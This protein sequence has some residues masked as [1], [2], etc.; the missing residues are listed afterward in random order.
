MNPSTNEFGVVGVILPD[1]R[2]DRDGAR[3]INED[4]GV[5][6]ITF[7]VISRDLVVQARYE[8]MR[9]AGESH[10]MAEMLATR[11]FPG[12]KT[13]A[14]FNE[15]KFS[16]DD[17]RIGAEQTWLRQQAEA[18]GVSTAG[19]WYCRGLASFPGDP[20]GW[21]GDRGDVL[22]VA[23]EKNMTVHG[24]VEH[25]GYE[26]DPGDDVTIGDDII[27]NEVQDILD[28]NPFADPDHVRDEVYRLRSG[29]VDPN[30]LL[31]GDYD[32]SHLRGA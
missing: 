20:T 4:V 30:P 21:V 24:Y 32:E 26:A 7:P 8:N 25:E 9:I 13:D 10:N 2:F 19:K 23:R 3:F 15:G 22:R 1:G 14:I 27:E 17:G 6:I 12:I 28:S 16:G 11:S 31:V 18:A 5:E 29:A